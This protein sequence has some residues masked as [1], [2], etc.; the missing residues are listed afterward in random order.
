MN[1]KIPHTVRDLANMI[2]DLPQDLPLSRLRG[3]SWGPDTEHCSVY[4]IERTKNDDGKDV[5]LIS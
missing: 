5:F 3:G 4:V 1:V 2:K